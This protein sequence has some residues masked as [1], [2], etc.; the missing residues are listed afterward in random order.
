MVV[1]GTA[2]DYGVT[3]D[4]PAYFYA[5]DLHIEWLVDFGQNVLRSDLDKSVQDENIKKAWHWDPYHVPHPPFSRIVSGITKALFS[6]YFDKFVAYRPDPRCSL[7]C[8]LP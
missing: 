5:S 7:P 3:W 1:A 8:W 4:E 6:S 2:G